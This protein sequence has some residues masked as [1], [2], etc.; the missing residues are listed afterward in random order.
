M[1]H[2]SDT[3]ILTPPTCSSNEANRL[4]T[5]IKEARLATVVLERKHTG[6][7]SDDDE[8]LALHKPAKDISSSSSDCLVESGSSFYEDEE[9]ETSFTSFS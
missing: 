6:Y 4:A 2:E 1:K 3:S 7:Q 9:E 5:R 8:E